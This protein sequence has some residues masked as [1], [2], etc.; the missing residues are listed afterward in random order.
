MCMHWITKLVPCREDGGNVEV[1]LPALWV[2]CT[3]NSN[4]FTFL[5]TFF[6]NLLNY[7]IRYVDSPNIPTPYITHLIQLL[8]ISYSHSF[9]VRINHLYAGMVLANFVAD[10]QDLK[11]AGPADWLNLTYFLSLTVCRTAIVCGRTG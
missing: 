4:H 7:M 11:L 3:S 1:I 8:H 6:N 2:T 10:R 9:S 5:N